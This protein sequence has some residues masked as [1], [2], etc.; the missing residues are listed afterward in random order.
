MAH[1]HINLVPVRIA[2]V[3]NDHHEVLDVL[4]KSALCPLPPTFVIAAALY[5]WGFTPRGAVDGPKIKS[6]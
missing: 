6:E 4:R 2:E 1:H 3:R 5:E